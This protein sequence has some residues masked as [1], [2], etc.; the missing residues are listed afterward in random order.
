VGH[1]ADAVKSARAA[2][3]TILET[4][5][6]MQSDDEHVLEKRELNRAIR[7]A[8]RSVLPNA[9]ATKIMVT[10]NARSLRYFLRVR[11][12]VLG[13]LE[14]RAVGAKMLEV[15]KPEAPALFSD[16]QVTQLADGP[17]VVYQENADSRRLP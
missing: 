8:A 2:Y 5:K 10:A 12:T 1:P 13:D 3:A 9:T 6:T 7:S 17:I 14:M 11:G 16:F 4:L 15:L